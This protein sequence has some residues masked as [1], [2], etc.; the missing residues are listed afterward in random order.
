MI[1]KSKGRRS[2]GNASTRPPEPSFVHQRRPLRRRFG[3]PLC[4]IGGIVFLLGNIGARTGIVF[5]PF[6]PHHVIAQ[7]G[8]GLLLIVGLLWATSSQD[9]RRKR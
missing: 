9:G 2:P 3:W 5:L 8:G 7:F 1:P 6:D 4:T